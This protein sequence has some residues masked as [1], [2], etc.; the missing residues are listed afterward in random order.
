MSGRFPGGA[1]VSSEAP[2]RR[3]R[4]DKAVSTMSRL[5]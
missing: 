2:A 4:D 3:I 5:T 1:A